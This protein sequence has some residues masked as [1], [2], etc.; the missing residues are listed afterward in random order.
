[1]AKKISIGLSTLLAFNMVATPLSAFAEETALEQNSVQDVSTKQQQDD[2]IKDEQFTS[3]KDESNDQ[4]VENSEEPQKEQDKEDEQST[5]VVEQ[6]NEPQVEK[7]EEIQTKENLQMESDNYAE[8]QVIDNGDGTASITG[9]SGV[10]T[11]LVIPDQIGG[12][13]VTVIG[14]E[15]FAGKG[16]TSVV[17]PTGLK[18]VEEAAFVY[19]Q[20]T[21]LVLPEGLEYTGISS[22]NYNSISDLTI[23]KSLDTI[24]DFS[25]QNNQLTEVVIPDSIDKLGMKAFGTNNLTAFTING[26][27]KD[28][29]TEN[30]GWVFDNEDGNPKK[31]RV[32]LVINGNVESIGEF[33]FQRDTLRNVTIKGNI[34][35]IGQFAFASD[36]NSTSGLESVV[37]EGDIGTIGDFAFRYSKNLTNLDIQGNVGEIKQ[38]AFASTKMENLNIQGSINELGTWALANSEIKDVNLQS[39]VNTIGE[40]AFSEIES[41]SITIEGSINKMDKF[42]IQDAK[43]GEFRVEGVINDIAETIAQNAVIDNFYVD[44]AINRIAQYG[45]HLSTI[46]NFTVQG[47]INTI[48]NGAFQISNIDNMYVNGNVEDIGGFAF[49]NGNYGNITINGDVNNIG[50][51]AFQLSTIGLIDINGDIGTIGENAFHGET[52]ANNHISEIK[53]SG[54]IGVIGTSAFLRLNMDKGVFVEG[55]VGI[56]ERE[57]FLRSNISTVSI[58]GNVDSINTMAFAY[59]ED[60]STPWSTGVSNILIGGRVKNTGSNS[61][62][63]IV[64]DKVIISK[65]IENIGATSFMF[66]NPNELDILK[67]TM[68]IGTSAFLSAKI[69]GGLTL[70]ET[71]ISIGESSFLN[72]ISDKLII[73]SPISIVSKDAFHSFKTVKDLVIPNTVVT[74]SEGAFSDVGLEK[75]KLSAKLD[76]IEDYAFNNH[77]LACVTIPSTVTAIGLDTFKTTEVK[78]KDFVMYGDKGSVAESYAATE[79]FTFIENDM[80]SNN[81]NPADWAIEVKYVDEQ[82]DLLDSKTINKPAKGSYT[83]NAKDIPGYTLKSDKAISVEVTSKEPNHTITFVYKKNSTPKPPATVLGTVTVNYIDESGNILE[84]KFSKELPLGAHIEHAKEIIGYEITGPKQQ[85]VEITKQNNQFTISFKYKKISSPDTSTPGTSQPEVISP[86]VT[87]ETQ[88][89]ESSNETGENHKGMRVIRDEG[90]GTYTTVPHFLDDNS[91]LKIT[92]KYNYGLL[93]T[94]RVAAPFKDIKG[95]FSYQEVEDLYNY[96]ITTGTVANTTYSPYVNISR[97]QFSAMIARALELRPSSTNYEF[98]D[99]SWYKNEVQALY[100]AGI[101]TGFPDGTFGERKPLSR[102]QAAAMIVRMLNYMGVETKPTV[103]ISLADMDRISDYAKEPVQFLATQGVLIS[104]KETSFNPFNELTRAQMAKVLMRSLR[105]SDWY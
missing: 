88:E 36:E 19:N 93:I 30:A 51:G 31:N 7:N 28:L 91:K 80:F 34:G 81:C 29:G 65:G 50:K 26:D 103:A 87:P 72:S 90:D 32:D 13:D 75:V 17:L 20:L 33:A 66:A 104:G 61:F 1:M 38:Y 99:V 67:D 84:T 27:V 83:E 53:V 73:N 58:G 96:L 89:P 39:F 86:P 35:S 71:V 23:P 105:I 64:S 44:G 16:L 52:N 5:P 47:F 101:V 70:P 43:I 78:P 94:E 76:S 12:K 8:F 4:Q 2:L 14:K 92:T 85:T 6:P 40:Y 79:G 22:F 9:Y 42:S 11:N 54:N 15:A 74:I 69:P 97:G 25:F 3:E 21:T 57:A 98:E 48:G 55:N 10:E 45:L 62:M 37:V 68:T 82:G 60:A 63:R 102:Q 77:K 100:E 46:K 56:I 18:R 41:D 49:Q 59:V 95:L 24:D